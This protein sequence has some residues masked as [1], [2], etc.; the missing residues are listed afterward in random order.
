MVVTVSFN[1]LDDEARKENRYRNIT[2]D[3]A[4]GQQQTWWW[5]I[6]EDCHDITYENLLKFLPR[7]TCNNKLILYTFNDKAF[8]AS[9]NIISGKG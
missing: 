1:I 6:N 7:N 4:G 8:P 5:D 3:P 9:L 2:I